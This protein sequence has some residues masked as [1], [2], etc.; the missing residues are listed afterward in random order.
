MS[1]R[2]A[3][4]LI[5]G[6]FCVTACVDGTTPDCATP[7]SPCYPGDAAQDG[8]QDGGQSDASDASSDGTTEAGD[9]A[10]DAVLD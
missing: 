8:S 1:A 9:A 2:A 7:S 10:T 3:L 5:A 6:T 4:L